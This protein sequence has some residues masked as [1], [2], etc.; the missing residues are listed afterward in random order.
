MRELTQ[1]ELDP[2]NCWQ[3]AIA[4]VL[5]LDASALPPQRHYDWCV[6]AVAEGTGDTIGPSYNAALVAYLRTHHR[7]AY[8]EIEPVLR[9]IVTLN[10]PG[11]HFMSGK[12]E[13]GAT[14]GGR[15]HI[16]VAQRG[17]M[18][19]D[20]HPSRAGLIGETRW[21]ALAP[22]PAAW[23][24]TWSRHM[25]PCACPACGAPPPIPDGAVYT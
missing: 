1:T 4:C 13:R 21:F 24:A 25:K 7:L 6:P 20:P 2:G 15:R 12:T 3:T 18:I 22:F 5:D 16:V 23:D 8:V 10:D 9:E 17:R 14:N 11:L 19:W